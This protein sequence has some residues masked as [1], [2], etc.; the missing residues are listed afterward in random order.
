MEN[1]VVVEQS[2]EIGLKTLLF[3]CYFK[4]LFTRILLSCP[5][6]QGCLWLF[7]SKRTQPCT[8]E[9]IHIANNPHA[10][11]FVN[12]GDGLKMMRIPGWDDTN[13]SKIELQ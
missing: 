11:C 10:G 3:P 1:Q 12:E 7:G 2:Y 5:G 4:T 6:Q 13:F 8:F 9:T